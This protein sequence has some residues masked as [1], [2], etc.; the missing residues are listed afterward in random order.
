MF[1]IYFLK[2]SKARQITHNHNNNNDIHKNKKNNY[3]KT[4]NNKERSKRKNH[5]KN[6]YFTTENYN[7][8]RPNP[9]PNFNIPM[10][11][12]NFPIYYT[13]FSS[14]IPYMS[15]GLNGFNSMNNLQ[16][17]Y[18]NIY[19]EN[20]YS[21]NNSSE[22]TQESS[23]EDK[24]YYDNFGENYYDSLQKGIKDISQIYNDNKLNRPKVSLLCHYY[25]NLDKNQDD[26]EYMSNEIQKLGDNLKKIFNFDTDNI[27][28]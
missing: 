17:N 21:K 12:T 8:N 18:N 4:E 14:N 13:P 6:K 22:N 25:C 23:T 20:K 26:E 7:I 16:Q 27:D 10:N 2:Y 5:T 11:F 9:I 1:L 24:N 19:I 3:N 15:L 28:K